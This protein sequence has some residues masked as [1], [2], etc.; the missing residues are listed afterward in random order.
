[1]LRRLHVWDL[2][3]KMKCVW[4]PLVP[5]LHQA[6]KK[7]TLNSNCLCVFITCVATTVVFELLLPSLAHTWWFCIQDVIFIGNKSS[8][9][10]NAVAPFTR[11]LR[12][13]DHFMFREVSNH[14]T[15]NPLWHLDFLIPSIFVNDWLGYLGQ[16]TASAWRQSFEQQLLGV[17]S[18]AQCQAVSLFI[19]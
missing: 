12:M 18:K 6:N 8:A 13:C 19:P 5:L 10:T 9:N 11:C 2:K 7:S 15:S 17:E 14:V 1:M 3:F 16:T 4:I